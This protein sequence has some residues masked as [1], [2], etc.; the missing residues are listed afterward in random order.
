MA[1]TAWNE[2]EERIRGFARANR[3]GPTDLARRLGYQG[4]SR[5][6]GSM[7]LAGK[8]GLPADRLELVA[9]LMETTIPALFTEGEQPADGEL[10]TNRI[11]NLARLMAWE[12]R[13]A[14]K[15]ARRA[16]TQAKLH[17]LAWSLERSFPKDGE[18]AP[19][20]RRRA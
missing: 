16:G 12:F 13:R 4:A 19:A 17:E 18:E 8:K 6:W 10:S 1:L 7:F 2:L 20:K 11:P 3:I 14:A 5:S 15:H 9:A